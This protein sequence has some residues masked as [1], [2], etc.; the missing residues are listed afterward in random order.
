MKY[1]AIILA[2]VVLFGGGYV[3]A[4]QLPRGYRNKN[5][6]NIRYNAANKWQGQVGKDDKGFCQFESDFYGLRAMAR[7]L[8]NYE[9]QGARTVADIINKYAPDSEN[10]T[11][12]YVISVSSALNV[13]PNG[14]VMVAPRLRELIAAIVKH[15]NGF[16]KYSAEEINAAI[17]A[18]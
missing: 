13:E 18:A 15:E 6:G 4:T 10:D 5:P 2:I 9:K 17:R 7:L 1:A 8:L 14:L 3:A 12:A 16:N 11:S